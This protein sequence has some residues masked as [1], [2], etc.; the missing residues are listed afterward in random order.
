M[1]VS[2]IH[3]MLIMEF[4]IQDLINLAL[5]KELLP[6]NEIKQRRKENRLSLARR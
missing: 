4:K 2:Q 5:N 3:I 6:Q 1:A